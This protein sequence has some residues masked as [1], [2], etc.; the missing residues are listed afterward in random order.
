MKRNKRS[1]LLGTMCLILL[2]SVIPVTATCGE[3]APAGPV[4]LKYH[5]W[6][7]EAHPATDWFK[8]WADKVTEY[9][10]GQVQFEY[11][12]G[13]ELGTA[14]DQ[15]SNME[16]GLFDIGYVSVGK[17]PSRLPLT[18]IA[19]LPWVPS[20]DAAA[21]YL[22]ICDMYELECLEDEW[23]NNGIKF[24]WPIAM[25][26]IYNIYL[27]DTPVYTLDDLEGLQIFAVGFMANALHLAGV[28]AIDLDPSEEYEALQK[29]IVDGGATCWA[30]AVSRH[31]EE[32]CEYMCT[33]R[34]GWGGPMIGIS[35]SAWNTLPASSRQAMADAT[36]ELGLWFDEQEDALIA[37]ATEQFEA[38]GMTIIEFPASEQQRYEDLAIVPVLEE[39]ISD[40]EAQGLPGREVYETLRDAA[41]H[42]E[43]TL[44]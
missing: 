38:G 17:D 31:L 11:F 36:Y 40:M 14:A 43:D 18:Q 15:M 22:A 5:S 26:D 27:V 25:G 6:I 39:W 16:S 32:V 30:P 19:S 9:S 3:S 34:V 35:L 4:T 44:D 24:V 29:N 12:Y 1:I 10:D 23:A 2:L 20:Y 33:I 8:W 42:Y 41:L 13:G 21:R 37:M 7:P 28:N